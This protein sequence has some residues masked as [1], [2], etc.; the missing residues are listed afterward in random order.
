MSD[1]RNGARLSRA[2]ELPLHKRRR[3]QWQ[4][5]AMG[6]GSREPRNTQNYVES[7]RGLLPQWGSAL[8]SRG[9]GILGYPGVRGRLAAMGLGSREPRNSSGPRS[10]SRT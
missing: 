10:A 2:E 5:A 3:T 8:A 6:L 7:D 1:S 4:R 9:T